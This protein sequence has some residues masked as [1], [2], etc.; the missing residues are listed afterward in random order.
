MKSLATLFIISILFVFFQACSGND[1]TGEEAQSFVIT[2]EAECENENSRTSYCVTEEV[3]ISTF[4]KVDI[5]TT[6]PFV[7][8]VDITGNKRNGILRSGTTRSCDS[9]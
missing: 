3:F 2:L 7:T 9:L 8:I 5:D 1:D 4:E 6:C